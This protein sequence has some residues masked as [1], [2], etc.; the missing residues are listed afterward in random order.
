VKKNQLN[1]LELKKNDRFGFG[2]I[3]LKPKKQNR[4]KTKKKPEK[5]NRANPKKTKP[6]PKNQAKSE[7]NRAKP[8]FVLKKSNRTELK[9][10]GLNRF[11]FF[12]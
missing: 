3:G 2:F 10:V 6:N 11:W 7:T 1:R 12:F 5:K 4:T 9:S 8:V